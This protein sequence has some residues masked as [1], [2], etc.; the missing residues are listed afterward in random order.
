MYRGNGPSFAWGE[1]RVSSS[2]PRLQTVHCCAPRFT[3]RRGSQNGLLLTRECLDPKWPPFEAT[4]FLWF[5]SIVYT[6]GHMIH[7]MWFGRKKT[8]TP[9]PTR[10]KQARTMCRPNRVKMRQEKHPYPKTTR[11]DKELQHRSNGTGIQPVKACFG[12]I[13]NDFATPLGR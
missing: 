10:T 7:R 8:R 1:D 13:I 3:C 12:H 9:T 2:S 4:R 11:E 6:H 5:A